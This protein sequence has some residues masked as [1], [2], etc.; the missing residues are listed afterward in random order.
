MEATREILEQLSFGI[1]VIGVAILLVGAVRFLIR[2][3]QYEFSR[4][5]GLACVDRIRALRL[6][7]GSYILLGL[8]FMIIADIIHTTVSRTLDEF[9]VLGILVL[10]R[11]AISYFL[12]RELSEAR[13]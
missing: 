6:E 9:L 1:D 3:V 2:Y 7:L 4:L 13:E 5:R 10:T 8:E 12:G 11:T